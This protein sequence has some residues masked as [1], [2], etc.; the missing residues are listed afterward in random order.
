MPLEDVN[1]HLKQK[2]LEFA[3]CSKCKRN[4]SFEPRLLADDFPALNIYYT[5][6]A[7][8][9]Y[10]IMIRRAVKW[11]VATGV[12]GLT[13]ASLHKNR[14]EVSTIGLLRFGRAAVTVGKIAVDYKL[15]LRGVA[16]K[17][18]EY[19]QLKSEVHFR[20]AKK[21]LDLCCKNGGAFIKVGQ[22]IGAL[23]Y[24]L[25]FEYVSTLKVLHNKAPKASIEDVLHVV[26]EDLGNDAAHIFKSFEPE[27]I[28]AA[29]LAQ[30]HLATLQDG[31]QVAVKVQHR[32]V[33]AH[34]KVD[35]AT[36]ELLVNIVDWMFP[37]FTFIWLAE[38]TKRNLPLELDFIHEGQ[39]AERVR[40][41]F[42]SLPWLK[43]PRIY[44]DYSTKRVLTMEYCAGGKVDDSSYIK[45]HNISPAEV[46]R[47]LGEL[48]S[49]MIFVQGY[50]HCDPHPGNI[51]VHKDENAKEAKIV[52]LDH[53]LYVDLTDQFRF[54]YSNMWLSLMKAD[55]KGVE[56]WGRKLGVGDLYALLACIVTGRS[57]T[58]VTKGIE[59]FKSTSDEEQEIKNNAAMYLPEITV[60]LSRVPREMLLVFKT[61]DLLRGIECSLGVKGAAG[62]FIAMSK[63]CIK[64]LY[65]EKMKDCQSYFSSFKIVVA[66]TV[67]YSRILI[68]QYYLWWTS[69]NFFSKLGMYS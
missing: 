57:W 5:I 36:M 42:S 65:D 30:V 60:L 27:P 43:V 9:I 61:N 69:F 62:S 55:L 15:S 13:L 32:S 14:W 67:A 68:Y 56:Y 17:S 45:A 31:T 1:K 39:N 4:F 8:Y 7:L 49:Q 63:C 40:R 58:A 6:Y 19:E 33:Q 47:K 53:G 10:Q 12:V 23:N 18:E 3:F 20:S 48:Y 38:E 25:P 29:S 51:L 59:K 24:L 41:M 28:G 46:S 2:V 22:H 37:E 35:M 11:S 52:L 50:V 54:E 26:K 64:T 21:L 44:W 16:A 34:A 66:R